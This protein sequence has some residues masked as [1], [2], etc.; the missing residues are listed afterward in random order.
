VESHKP[1][2]TEGERGINPSSV[3]H[4]ELVWGPRRERKAS[5]VKSSRS[6]EEE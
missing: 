6:G 1:L 2:K 4:P 3:I 5:K